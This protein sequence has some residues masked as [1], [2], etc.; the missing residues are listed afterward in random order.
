MTP[1][2][3]IPRGTEAPLERSL[4]E[5]VDTF[6]DASLSEAT[7]RAYRADLRA[8]E[9]WCV[10]KGRS[11]L[12]ASEGTVESYLIDLASEG[13]KVSTLRRALSAISQAHTLKG[14]PSPRERA[15]VKRTIQGIAKR[16]G[17]P[18]VRKE[19]VRVDTMGLLLAQLPDSIVGVRDRA[20]LL[21][22]FA[23][24]FRR[25]ELVAL[26]VGDLEFTNDGI[27]VTIRRSKTDQEGRGR[28]L[29]IPYGSTAPRCPVRS[30]KAW[31]E[32][33]KTTEG[34][35]FRPVSRWKGARAERLAPQGVA[36]VVK[37]Y[38]K[39]A[40]IANWEKFAGHSL[41]RGL[42]SSAKKAGKSMHSIMAQTGHTS[43]DM[44]NRYVQDETV[45]EENAAAGLL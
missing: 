7:R 42:V 30:V 39:R 26:D 16:I 8:Y 33:S 18:Q 32:L 22:G 20:L 37:R 14:Y 43:F 10:E 19:P 21:L 5:L 38:A 36:N 9:A 11:P 27:R 40:G 31:L 1:S 3:L 24:G 12:P 17:A 29:G 4:L 2:E 35:V 45:F 23:G 25:S 28:V 41:R 6:V 34:P 13:L 15:V 44:V